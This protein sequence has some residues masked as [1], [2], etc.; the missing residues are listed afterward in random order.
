MLVQDVEQINK[1]VEDALEKK[2]LECKIKLPPHDK[3]K[4]KTFSQCIKAARSY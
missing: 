4:P 2:L 1:E 3:E